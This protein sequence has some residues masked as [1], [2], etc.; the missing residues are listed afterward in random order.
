MPVTPL[1]YGLEQ[2][3]RA[4][5]GHFSSVVQEF[6]MLRS[7]ADHSI[8]Y[9][10]NSSGQCIYLV[11]YVDDIV[12]TG[13]DEDGIQKLK[14]HLFTHFQ[15][16]NLGKLK[17]FMGIEIAQSSSGVVL[18]QRKYAL[19]ILEE[20]S[21]LDCKSIDTPMV[22]NVKLVPGQGESLGDPGRYRRL[23]GKLNYLTI[24]LPDISFPVS[25]VSQFLQSPCDSH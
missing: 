24:T 23:V 16:K 21:M 15:T 12:I 6:G 14:K 19:D 5:F 13:S 20:T 9:P 22:P 2:S 17:Y 4:W 1:S 25:V 10:H 11:V 8:F 7:T 18:S 3:P